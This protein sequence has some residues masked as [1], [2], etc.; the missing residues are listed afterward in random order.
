MTIAHANPE[1]R[2]ITKVAVNKTVHSCWTEHR[3]LHV[4]FNDSTELIVAWGDSHAELKAKRVLGSLPAVPALFG[5]V[6]SILGGKTVEYCYINDQDDLVLRTH[7]G[8]EMVIG[9]DSEPVIR[10]MDVK[11]KLPTPPAAGG[12]AFGWPS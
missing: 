12:F 1:K 7:C 10:R 11:I 8:H 5:P 2:R 6:S 4:I 3:D 9:Y